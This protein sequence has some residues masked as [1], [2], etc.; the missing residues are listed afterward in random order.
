VALREEF[1]ETG[2]QLF[3]WRSYLP[4]AFLPL[5]VLALGDYA[6]T[7]VDDRLGPR[8]D[9]VCVGL[10]FLGL[11]LRAMVVGQTP[12]RTSGRN[13][14]EQVADTLNTTGMYSVVR[15]PLYLGNFLSWLGIA[16]FTQ[17]LLTVVASAMA[18]ALY[19]ER[20]MFAEEAFLRGRFGTD[21][22]LWAD[23]TPAFFPRPSHWK[24]SAV[25]FSWKL[26]LLREYSGMFAIVSTFTVFEAIRTWMERG[27]PRL[28][29][30]W[31]AFF[32]LG[33]LLYAG[34]RRAK[35]VGRRS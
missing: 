30:G 1:E 11:A 3:R 17:S 19:Y 10:S 28:G 27:V 12:A 22:A 21:F 7:P 23:R 24:P 32:L 15:H 16:L 9:A 8:W 31:T 25:P 18:F 13:T 14:L 34:L 4:L 5:F 2:S 33:L 29:A 26:V 35:K 20:I 6:Q